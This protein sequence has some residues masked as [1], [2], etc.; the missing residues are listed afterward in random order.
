MIE[1]LIKL[2][3]GIYGEGEIKLH[4]AQI[5]E[6]DHLRVGEAM[7]SRVD[8]YGF[9]VKEFEDALADYTKSKHVMATCSGT[10]ALFAIL[11]HFDDRDSVW[12][13]NYTFKGTLNAAQKAGFDYGYSDVCPDTFGMSSFWMDD[14]EIV[15]MPVYL[16]GMP[17]DMNLRSGVVIE[18]AC[19]ALGTFYRGKHAGKM[20]EAGALS[21]NGNKII[22]TG[23]GGAVLTDDDVLADEIREFIAKDFNLRMPALNAALGLSQLMRIEDIVSVKREIAHMYQE[24]FEGSQIRCLS[25]PKG[26]RSNYWLSTIILPTSKMRDDWFDILAGDGIEARKGFQVLGPEVPTPVV[27]EYEGRVLCLPSGVPG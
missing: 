3:R 23:G 15:N 5:T 25:E 14:S 8:C 2:I 4:P 19:Q 26:T 11:C 6:E 21:F 16:F 24:F 20:G 10:A 9:H 27:Y 7:N 1:E 12:L 17:Y 22:T 13:P 18:D